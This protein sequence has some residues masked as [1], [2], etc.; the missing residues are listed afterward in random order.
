MFSGKAS[1]LNNTVKASLYKNENVVMSMHLTAKQRKGREV[2]S[3]SYQSTERVFITL[4]TGLRVTV[5][6]KNKKG[7][8]EP[9]EKICKF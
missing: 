8:I 2:V 4:H 1:W 7:R 9:S 5:R 3:A 6:V